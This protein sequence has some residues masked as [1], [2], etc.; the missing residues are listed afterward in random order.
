VKRVEREQNFRQFPEASLFPD[1]PI[2]HLLPRPRGFPQER[3]AGFHGQIELKTT[4][5]NAPAHFAPTMPLHQLVE[6]GLQRDAV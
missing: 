4:D 5:G 1:E 6:Q 2:F 3:E